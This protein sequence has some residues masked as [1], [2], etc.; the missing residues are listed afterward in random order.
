MGDVSR[1]LSHNR[2]HGNIILPE[3]IAHAPV[4]PSCL[5]P[6]VCMQWPLPTKEFKHGRF[7]R[8]PSTELVIRTYFNIHGMKI[9]RPVMYH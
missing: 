7:A 8:I 6:L 9:P 3:G 1:S 4:T 5:N 2:T